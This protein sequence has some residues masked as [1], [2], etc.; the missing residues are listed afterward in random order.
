MTTRRKPRK[1]RRRFGT[2]VPAKQKKATKTSRDARNLPTASPQDDAPA[3][4]PQTL[5]SPNCSPTGHTVGASTSD[6]QLTWGKA[7]GGSTMTPC[8]LGKGCHQ[9]ASVGTAVTP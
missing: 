4:D 7:S 8:T 6:N 2:P 9:T 3:R 5:C 1:K